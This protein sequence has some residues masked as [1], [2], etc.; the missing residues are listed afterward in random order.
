M[1]RNYTH[2]D[3]V[4]F[5]NPITIQVSIKTTQLS[6]VSILIFKKIWCIS[7]A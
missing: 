4:I 3:Q 1:Y 6:S 7:I 2:N 5:G